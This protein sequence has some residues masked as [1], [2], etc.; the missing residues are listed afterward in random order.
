MIHDSDGIILSVAPPHKERM[1][2]GSCASVERTRSYTA[3]TLASNRAGGIAKGV[4]IVM[5]A[6][7][8]GEG[9]REVATMPPIECPSTRIWVFAGYRDKM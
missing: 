8:W 4:A 3:S 5:I 7:M 1:G 9:R 6:E 2:V